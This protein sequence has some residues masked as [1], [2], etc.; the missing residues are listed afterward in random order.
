MSASALKVPCPNPDCTGLVS[1]DVK[2]CI[3]CRHRLTVC[4]HCKGVMSETIGFCPRCGYDAETVPAPDGKEPARAEAVA[5]VPPEPLAP[6][7]RAFPEKPRADAGGCAAEPGEAPAGDLSPAVA[8][9]EPIE[10]QMTVLVSEDALRRALA[11]AYYR[12]ALAGAD[13]RGAAE[14]LEAIRRAMAVHADA[15]RT[16]DGISQQ[17]AVADPDRLRPVLID[18][19]QWFRQELLSNHVTRLHGLFT[20]NPALGWVAWLRTYVECLVAWRIDFCRTLADE[21]FPFPAAEEPGFGA[22]ALRRTTRWMLQERWAE[23]YQFLLLLTGQEVLPRWHRAR[24]LVTAAEIL[25]YHLEKP[26][27][28][29]DLVARAEQLAPADPRTLCGRGQCFERPQGVGKARE[30]FQRSIDASPDLV[31]GYVLMGDTYGDEGRLDEAEGWYRAAIRRCAG[32]V[33]GYLRLLRLYGRPERFPQKEGEL[34]PVLKLITALDATDEYAALLY[35]ADAYVQNG[36]YEEAQACYRKAIALEPARPDGHVNQGYAYFAQGSYDKARAALEEAIAVAPE[37]FDGYWALA[38]VDEHQQN[39]GAALERYEQCLPRRPEWE[40]RIRVRIGEMHRKLGDLP[41]AEEELLKA[42]RLEAEDDRPAA[43]RPLHELADHYYREGDV[44]DKALALYDRIAE[45][46]GGVY[47]AEYHNRCGNVKYFLGD[48]AAAAEYYRRATDVSPETAVYHS[49][50]GLAYRWLQ[51][52]SGARKEF[53]AALRLGGPE[54][55]HRSEMARTFNQEG[56][57]FYSHGEYQEAIERYRQALRFQPED[58]V[59]HANIA[60]AWERLTF[61]DGRLED[62]D[63]AITAIERAREL[64]PQESEYSGTRTR[65]RCSRLRKVRAAD[66]SARSSALPPA[67]G[68]VPIEVEVSEGLRPYVEDPGGGRMAH[69]LAER[70]RDLREWFWSDYGVLF[71]EIT[72]R[73]GDASG[74]SY[75]VSLMGTLVSANQ[76]PLG[77]R[78]VI[79][80][81]ADLQAWGVSGERT[82]NPASGAEAYWIAEKDHDKL[83][84][85][86]QHHW[87]VTDYLVLHLMNLI[88]K[89]LHRFVG[90]QEVADLMEAAGDGDEPLSTSLADRLTPLTQVI[91]ALLA[92]RVPVSAFR[93][94]CAR[95]TQLYEPGRSLSAIVEELRSLPPVRT[96]L[97]GNSQDGTHVRLGSRFEEEIRRCIRMSGPE[98]LLAMEP[99]ACQEALRIVR[100]RVQGLTGTVDLVVSDPEV[101]PLVRRLI[102]LEF[103]HFMV[104][105]RREALSD[106]ESRVVAELEL[107][108]GWSDGAGDRE[109]SHEL[110]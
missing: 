94:I 104:L 101:R 15:F 62:I 58:A 10:A 98:P 5:E 76:V 105:S 26:A 108:E 52:W 63:R 95:F 16:W 73:V 20:R 80:T 28:A 19:R 30:F 42:L 21:A 103:P 22:E 92:E 55:T 12:A 85:A 110:A 68:I 90:H 40:A 51:N 47:T 78:L 66:A 106:W 70:V 83:E 44:P 38:W 71:P 107:P 43:L 37:A 60:R 54:D 7:A 24:L 25:L 86:G 91:R 39:W 17:I 67:L 32:S 69:N 84:A 1:P 35:V 34:L 100:E 72:F 31:D 65:L 75:I 97:P 11:D 46:L 88:R 56:N 50:L 9:E 49:N 18:F 99:Q 48:Y 13:M 79:G 45:V 29:R 82:E 74:E 96:E 33:S 4:G 59:F 3:R 81:Q 6:E 41:A 77:K 64:A 109:G 53:E 57:A 87:S 89:N 23:V 14:T 2:W 27:K 36:R 93:E 102:E 8:G 61:P